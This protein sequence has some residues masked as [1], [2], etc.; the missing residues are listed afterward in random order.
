M[1]SSCESKHCDPKFASL[2]KK[3][4]VILKALVDILERDDKSYVMS[5]TFHGPINF[6]TP[7]TNE[8]ESN[9]NDE[10]SEEEEDEASE[11][12]DEEDEYEAKQANSDSIE[13]KDQS[14]S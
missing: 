6:N 14:A 12:E 5:G 3:L 8:G 9:E 2:H 4:D 7:K 13:T 10:Y 11:D 1:M